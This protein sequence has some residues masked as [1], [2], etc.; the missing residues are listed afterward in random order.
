MGDLPQI[1]HAVQ[2]PRGGVIFQGNRPC[3]GLFLSKPD[4]K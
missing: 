3:K 1:T 2:G 4:V